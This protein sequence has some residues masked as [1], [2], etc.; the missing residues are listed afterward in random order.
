MQE[1]IIDEM[2]RPP[3]NS[4]VFRVIFFSSIVRTDERYSK[5]V[6]ESGLS[7]GVSSKNFSIS[8]VLPHRFS[9]KK[10]NVFAETAVPAASYVLRF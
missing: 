3:P 6:V 10:T 4:Y 8:E 1:L 9:P 7:L 5:A 2:L